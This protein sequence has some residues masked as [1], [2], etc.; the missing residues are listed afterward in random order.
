MLVP[1]GLTDAIFS[2]KC[3]WIR[4]VTWKQQVMSEN[5]W[6]IFI[7]TF[8][9]LIHLVVQCSFKWYSLILFIL[10]HQW[11]TAAKSLKPVNYFKNAHLW[12]TDPH[13][14]VCVFE[15]LHCQKLCLPCEMDK[16]LYQ[17]LQFQSSQEALKLVS[18][19]RKD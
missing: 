12:Q 17:L 2:I 7:R 10:W 13:Q 18:F 5:F 15:Q 1:L 11:P 16:S 4:T 19:E 3:F 8:S 6:M 14:S 9:K